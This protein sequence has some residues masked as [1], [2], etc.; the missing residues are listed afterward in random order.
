MIDT[1]DTIKPA[2]TLTKTVNNGVD[3]KDL[4]DRFAKPNVGSITYDEGYNVR[5]HK[6]EIEFADWLHS[7]YGGNI[8]LLS[9]INQNKISTPDYIWNNK[10]WDLKTVTTEK[11][12]NSAVRKG[13]KQIANNPGGV[14]LNYGDSNI[15]LK[16]LQEIIDKRMQWYKDATVDIMIVHNKSV[17]KIMRYGRK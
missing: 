16:S 7:Y 4:Y 2:K 15:S 3:V 1:S 17:I 9:E 8:H 5:T 12:A 14:I 10:L 11:A 13:L 6:A